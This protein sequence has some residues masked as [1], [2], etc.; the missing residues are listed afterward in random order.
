MNAM[1]GIGSTEIVVFAIFFVLVLLRK[2]APSWL[3]A[4]ASPREKSIG[5]RFALKDLFASTALIALGIAWI[6]VA[7]PDLGFS[8]DPLEL[9]MW[10]FV[11]GGV[12][13]G[14]GLLAPF[15]AA[16]IGA[17][18]GAFVNLLLIGTATAY[19]WPTF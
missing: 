12:F 14:A 10:L 2:G 4:R 11:I 6:L 5:L 13:I 17:A 19:G 8:I 7:L 18:L 3:A 15:R 1:F 16:L 9:P